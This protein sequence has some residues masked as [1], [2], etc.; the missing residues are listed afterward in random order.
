MGDPVI[1]LQLA[2]GALGNR[3]WGDKDGNRYIGIVMITF[4]AVWAN[5]ALV[6]WFPVMYALYFAFRMPGTG[7]TF[8]AACRGENISGAIVR[9]SMA[10]FIG[11]AA[12]LI[13]N[14]PCHLYVALAFP[15]IV[16]FYW[17]GGQVWRGTRAGEIGELLTG[18]Y[19]VALVYPW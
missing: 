4:A 13:D 8:L 9:A 11:I 19:L 15:V 14:N 10:Q 3:S 5:L 12:T 16:F 17:F 6:Y 1:A 2:I 7:K 18:A